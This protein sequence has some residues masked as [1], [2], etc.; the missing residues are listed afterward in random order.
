MDKHTFGLSGVQFKAIVSHPDMSS[1][2]TGLENRR[3]LLDIGA[4]DIDGGVIRKQYSSRR[5]DC[6][7]EVINEGGK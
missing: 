3:D 1:I 4:T 6:L 5:R 2:K 7:W